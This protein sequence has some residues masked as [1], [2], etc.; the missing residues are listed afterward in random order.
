MP[1]RVSMGSLR[2]SLHV[3]SV[4]GGDINQSKSVPMMSLVTCGGK[5]ILTNQILDVSAGG[6]HGSPWVVSVGLHGY[7]SM[8]GG[9]IN[10]QVVS[11]GG[12]CMW[13][14]WV[15][16]WIGGK[17]KSVPLTVIWWQGARQMSD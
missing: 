5:A 4:G 2:G 1:P 12:L 10:P 6:L 16:W 7:V 9:D 17:A 15:V 8:G 13:S 11:A 14:P 3:V